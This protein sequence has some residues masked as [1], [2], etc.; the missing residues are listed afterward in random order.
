MCKKPFASAAQLLGY[1]SGYCT[2]NKKKIDWFLPGITHDD[3]DN[4]VMLF[5]SVSPIIYFLFQ[6]FLLTSFPLCMFCSII[7]CD[8]HCKQHKPSG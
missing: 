7:K 2:S 5:F 3:F 1:R 8:M 4:N 6:R